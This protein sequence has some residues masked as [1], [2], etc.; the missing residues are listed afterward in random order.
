[1]KKFTLFVCILLSSYSYSLAQDI[2]VKKFELIV[3]DQTAPLSPRKDL[4]GVI[5]GLVKAQFEFDNSNKKKV[6]SH[7]TPPLAEIYVNNQ[8]I[9]HGKEKS[10]AI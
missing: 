1:M 9:H 6:V 10:S 4:N 8:Q 3:K 2:E 5:C 7:I